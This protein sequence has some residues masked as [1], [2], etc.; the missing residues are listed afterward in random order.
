[1]KRL[2]VLSLV[3]L[4]LFS[5]PV[6]VSAKEDGQAVFVPLHVYMDSG[7]HALGAWQ[8]ELKVTSGHARIVGVEGGEHEAF[9]KAPYYDPKALSQ[10]RII[11]AAFSTGAVLPHG[12][13]R[14]ATLHLMVEGDADYEII[15]MVTADAEGRVIPAAIFYEQG[16]LQ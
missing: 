13:T 1:M 3:L 9:Q 14:V 15:P 12:R 7:E 4:P 11:V 2:C 5:G 16:D 6:T 10:D 8:F